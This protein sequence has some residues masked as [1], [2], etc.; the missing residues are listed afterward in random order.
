MHWYYLIAAIVFEVCGTVC[1][2]LSDGLEKVVPSI[3]VYVFYI[4]S[5]YLLATA[6][7][8]ID[9]GVAYAIWAGTGTALIAVIGVTYFREPLTAAKVIC[10]LLVIVGVIGLKLNSVPTENSAAIPPSIDANTH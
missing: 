8:H 7:K 3:L 2:K 6:I 10:T 1:M 4:A 5:F 9:V